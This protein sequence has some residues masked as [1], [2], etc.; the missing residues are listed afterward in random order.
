M[1]ETAGLCATCARAT[2]TKHPR[3]GRD[4]VRCQ[5]A[6][7]DP[8]FERYPRLPVLT[9]GGYERETKEKRG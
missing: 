9:C 5:L 2:R 1:S 7:T 6:E 4:Y 8:R 3:G